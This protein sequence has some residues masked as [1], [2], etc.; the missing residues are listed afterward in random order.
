[1]REGW[2]VVASAMAPTRWRPR[3]N[4]QQRHLCFLFKAKTDIG[5]AFFFSLVVRGRKHVILPT[6]A[7]FDIITEAVSYGLENRVGKFKFPTFF[8]T[9]LLGLKNRVGSEQSVGWRS[10]CHVLPAHRS[11]CGLAT[12]MC[13]KATQCPRTPCYVHSP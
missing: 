6:T 9:W 3:P 8:Q 4:K 7:V 10:Y 5:K 11:R 13:Q 1:M 2:V 12:E